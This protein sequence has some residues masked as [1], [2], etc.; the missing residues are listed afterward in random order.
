L[1]KGKRK[2]KIDED[3][4]GKRKEKHEDLMKI[5]QRK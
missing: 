3:L 4:I 2:T 5:L 1:G